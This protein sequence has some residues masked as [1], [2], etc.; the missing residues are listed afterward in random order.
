M[1]L[2][3]AKRGNA[4]S[5]VSISRFQE[6]RSSAYRGWFARDH[7]GIAL[8]L[9]ISLAT[10]TRCSCQAAPAVIGPWE[11]I[12]VGGTFSAYRLDYG[13]RLLM[14]AAGYID[15]SY[16]NHCGIEAEG[17]WLW[18]HQRDNVRESTY[19]IGPRFTLNGIGGTR[20]KFRPYVKF[21]V[22]AAHFH[23]PYRYATGNY[24][25]LGP[26]GGID[27][28]VNSRIR[29]RLIDVEYQSWPQFTYGALSSI[30]VSTGLRFRL[31]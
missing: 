23:Y 11:T 24:L 19:L 30:G 29:L 27:Y 2:F 3:I 31:F 16:T 20:K 10:T 6:Q 9:A 8:L 22:G 15:A 7:L 5:V 12:A 25:V 21:E 13:D 1:N 18:L 4:P 17:Q 14:G 28:R 26:G